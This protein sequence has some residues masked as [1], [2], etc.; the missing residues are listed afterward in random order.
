VF[1]ARKF[2]VR[3]YGQPLTALMAA[4]ETTKDRIGDGIV[5]TNVS[6][7]QMDAADLEYRVDIEGKDPIK[8]IKAS[9][10]VALKKTLDLFLSPTHADGDLLQTSKIEFT[11]TK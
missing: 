1:Y 2:H 11:L 10:S 4:I 6:I 3:L 8:Y 9:V 5:F 7:R